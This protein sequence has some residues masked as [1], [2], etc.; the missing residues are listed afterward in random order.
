MATILTQT[1]ALSAFPLTSAT[2][3]T[4]LA[5]QCEQSVDALL[6]SSDPAVRLNLCSR[7]AYCLGQLQLTLDEPIPS[8][9]IESLTVDDL[10]TSAPRFEPDA[11]LLC[12]YCLALVKLLT[13]RVVVPQME[14]TLIGLL[15][16]LVNY[17]A[18][19]LKAPRWIRTAAGVRFIEEIALES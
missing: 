13:D 16:E 2:D 8:H 14:Q 3:F 15:F 5:E 7:L 12:E 19:E 6:E 1:Q 18:D 11:V 10:P 9:L 4:V 17:F